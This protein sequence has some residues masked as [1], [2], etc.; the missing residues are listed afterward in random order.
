MTVVANNT[1]S[2]EEVRNPILLKSN[3]SG[4]MTDNKIAELDSKVCAELALDKGLSTNTWKRVVGT[5]EPHKVHNHSKRTL[6]IIADYLGCDSWE[7]LTENIDDVRRGLRTPS[8]DESEFI[9][10]GK[11]RLCMQNMRKG[12]IIRIEYKPSRMIEAERI[13]KDTYRVMNSHNAKLK[14]ND[15][16]TA[17]D[18]TKGDPFTVYD[19]I[20]NGCNIGDY[21]SAIRHSIEKISISHTK[22]NIF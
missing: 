5:L 4:A 13:G 14:N 21:K 19:V 16:F 7:E 20:R 1:I 11:T 18:F 17:F 3:I 2:M 22:S 15:I 9:N 6:S 12:D 8:M 10:N